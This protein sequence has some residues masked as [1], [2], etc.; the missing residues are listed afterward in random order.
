M[1]YFI[2]ALQSTHYSMFLSLSRS[3]THTRTFQT[4][5]GSISTRVVSAHCFGESLGH[6]S[7]QDKSQASFLPSSVLFLPLPS[8]TAEL[9]WFNHQLVAHMTGEGEEGGWGCGGEWWWWGQLLLNV[10]PVF[11]ADISESVQEFIRQSFWIKTELF[12]FIFIYWTLYSSKTPLW[13][14]VKVCSTG[15]R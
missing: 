5:S 2:W 8:W 6:N 10:A 4:V 14:S 12:F 3:R 7:N 11:L 15:C 13:A 9:A 1:V